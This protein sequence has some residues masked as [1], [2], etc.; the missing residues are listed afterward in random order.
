MPTISTG[1]DSIDPK[2]PSNCNINF[3]TLQTRTG[4]FYAVAEKPEH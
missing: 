2:V 3:D 4:H 1:I